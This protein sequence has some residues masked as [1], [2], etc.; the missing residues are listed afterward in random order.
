MAAR[1]QVNSTGKISV[2]RKKVVPAPVSYARGEWINFKLSLQ[3]DNQSLAVFVNGKEVISEIGFLRI[4]IARIDLKYV[5][6]G[7]G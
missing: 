4:L 6:E 7:T 2:V 5:R 3:T 1:L